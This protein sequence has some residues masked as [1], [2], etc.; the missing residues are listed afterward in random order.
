MFF[1][2]TVEITK[3]DFVTET[4]TTILSNIGG[5]MGMWL[6]LGMVQAVGILVNYTFRLWDRLTQNKER[7]VWEEQRS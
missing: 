2:K 7:R 6:G 5:A 1:M 3:T 4:Y